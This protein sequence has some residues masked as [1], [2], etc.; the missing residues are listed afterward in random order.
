ME[1]FYVVNANLPQ[2]LHSMYNLV[3]VSLSNPFPKT[4]VIKEY[5]QT[6]NSVIYPG[7]QACSDLKALG[8]NPL[9]IHC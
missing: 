8:G 1:A 5:K 9:P 6:L 3:W 4:T 7:L 2:M